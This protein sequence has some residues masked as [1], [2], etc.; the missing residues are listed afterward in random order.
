MSSDLQYRNT[1]C[2]L[3]QESLGKRMQNISKAPLQPK[4]FFKIC[5]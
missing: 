3:A 2:D 4:T 5:S 1:L